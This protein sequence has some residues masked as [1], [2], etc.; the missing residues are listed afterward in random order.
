MAATCAGRDDFC[1]VRLFVD[2]IE[3]PLRDLNRK[4]IFLGERTEGTGHSA[5]SG[6]ENSCFSSWQTFCKASHKRRL[7]DGLGVAMGMNRDCLGALAEMKR[8]AFSL[9]QIVEKFFKE[10]TALCDILCVF[11]FQFAIIFDEHRPA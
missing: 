4:I 11:D 1:S 2:R 7:H 8:I 5:A 6:I 10:K 3:Q 9:E